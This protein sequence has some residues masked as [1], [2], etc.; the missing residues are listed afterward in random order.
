M[1]DELGEWNWNE[2]ENLLPMEIILR[3]DAVRPLSSSIRDRPIWS[4]TPNHQFQILTNVGQVRRHVTNDG[5][6]PMSGYPN[7]DANH[8]LRSCSAAQLVSG[9][10]VHGDRWADF[11]SLSIKDGHNGRH[12]SVIATDVRLQQECVVSNVNNRT[13][14]RSVMLATRELVH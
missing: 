8:V 7:E 12:D 11:I 14:N 2:F 13:T 3:I 1:I 4:L 9:I 6:G 5:S 10:F